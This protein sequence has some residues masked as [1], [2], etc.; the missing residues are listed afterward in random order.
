MLQV[1]VGN[2]TGFDVLLSANVTHGQIQSERG[3]DR[4]RERKRERRMRE[5]E[6]EK[7]IKFIRRER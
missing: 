1:A 3:R 7:V 4:D 2:Q 6:G 5:S